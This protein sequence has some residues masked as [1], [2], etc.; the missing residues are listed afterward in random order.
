MAERLRGNR[1]GQLADLAIVDG[2]GDSEGDDRVLVVRCD[3]AF[4]RNMNKAQVSARGQRV[5]L[6]TPPRDSQ[7]DAIREQLG[8]NVLPVTVPY[9]SVVAQRSY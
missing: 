3:R 5:L 4:S 1:C 6:V 8:N 2:P 9:D 7:E